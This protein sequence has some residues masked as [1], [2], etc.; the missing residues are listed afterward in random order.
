MTLAE[1]GSQIGLAPSSVSD[2]ETGRSL[3]PK[4]DAAVRLHELHKALVSDAA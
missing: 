1:I 4:G 2:I 3:E